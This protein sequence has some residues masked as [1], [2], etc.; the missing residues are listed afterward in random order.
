MDLA[1]EGRNE[2]DP[3]CVGLIDVAFITSYEIVS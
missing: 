1:L 3:L 2:G